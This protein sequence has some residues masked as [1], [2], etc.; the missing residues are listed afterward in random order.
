MAVTILA[1][2]VD[3]HGE[4]AWML[5]SELIIDLLIHDL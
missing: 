5:I 3:Y 1:L 4:S 2:A